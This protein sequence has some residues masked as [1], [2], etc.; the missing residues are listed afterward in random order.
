[1]LIFANFFL[2]NEKK[3]FLWTFF[4]GPDDIIQK[5]FDL[6]SCVISS[7]KVQTQNLPI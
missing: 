7:K 1:M 3:F 2:R 6:P 4:L 5:N